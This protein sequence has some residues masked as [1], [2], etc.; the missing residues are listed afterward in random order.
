MFGGRTR[1]SKSGG[2]RLS[3]RAGLC[4]P[5]AAV[6]QA[7]RGKDGGFPFFSSTGFARQNLVEMRRNSGE[8]GLEWMPGCE[9]EGI[10]HIHNE[11]T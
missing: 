7:H 9:A 5:T 3:I 8:L 10:I 1:F 4:G 11:N 2:R 6:A